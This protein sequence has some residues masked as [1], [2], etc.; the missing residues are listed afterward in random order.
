MTP[1]GRNRRVFG[2][3]VDV[4]D[5]NLRRLRRADFP[6]LGAW[7]AQ[8]HVA[9]WWNHDVSPQGVETDFGPTVDGHDLADIFIA[10]ANGHAFGLVQ[11]YT[12]ADNPGY[13]VELAELVPVAGASLSIDYLVGE[14]DALRRGW[15][16]AMIRAVVAT[17]WRDYPLAPAVV[18]PVHATNAA[19]WRVLERAGF[20]RV[21]AG[22]LTP[23]NPIDDHAHFV[24]QFDRPVGPCGK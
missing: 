10:S 20:R 9:R 11:R 8:P 21:A 2:T 7:L 1:I 19:S 5:L 12:F 24:Y 6:M 14:P 13:M 18:V 4:N 16:T 23:D 3:M 15:G 17:T 22:P